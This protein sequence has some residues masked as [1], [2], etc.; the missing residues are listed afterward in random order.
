MQKQYKIRKFINKIQKKTIYIALSYLLFSFVIGYYLNA[1]L[2][3]GIFNS[4]NVKLSKITAFMLHCNWGV[5]VIPSFIIVFLL[6]YKDLTYSQ[7][8]IEIINQITT[9]ALVVLLLTYTA[10]IMM[11]LV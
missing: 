2:L 1:T 10:L 4:S 11:N 9:N 5:Y 7:K 3:S 6:V 8:C